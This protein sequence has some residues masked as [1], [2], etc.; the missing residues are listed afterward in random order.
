MANDKDDLNYTPDPLAALGPE[1]EK[2]LKRRRARNGM[3]WTI[4]AF[5]L[6]ILFAVFSH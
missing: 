5:I 2:A 6:G 3:I 4:L 1:G